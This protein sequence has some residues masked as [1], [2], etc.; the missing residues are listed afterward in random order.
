MNPYQ[1][2]VRSMIVGI[3]KLMHNLYK[4]H[5]KNIKMIRRI[6]LMESMT[7]YHWN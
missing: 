2:K 3:S 1:I 6:K 7:P 5:T 4:P